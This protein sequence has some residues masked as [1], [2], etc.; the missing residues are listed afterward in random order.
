MN[1]AAQQYV[2]LVLAMGEHDADYVDSYY[3]PPSWREEVRAAKQT[4]PEIHASA[5]ALRET[6]ASADRPLEGIESLRLDYL[7][8]QTDALIARV[9]MLFE[10]GSRQ[11]AVKT[12][13][14]TADRRLPTADWEAASR[15]M[16]SRMRST[17]RS[18]R[19]TEKTISARS[20]P[21][22]TR[23]SAASA[24]SPRAWK[25]FARSSRFPAR[26]STPSSPPPS[27][28]AAP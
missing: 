18:H 28:S 22:S 6:L 7:H 21:P 8:R 1:D 26:S 13:E 16:K 10:V 2:R 17:T 25:R 14:A 15:S 20:T 23:S 4:L 3:G 19:P 24:P 27:T 5:V 9:E 12:T 11:S